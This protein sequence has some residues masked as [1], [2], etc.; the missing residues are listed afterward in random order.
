M[1]KSDHATTVDSDAPAD[2]IGM[3]DEQLLARLEYLEFGKEDAALL[4][5][6]HEQLRACWEK[7]GERFYAYL[8]STPALQPYLDD[9]ALARLKCHQSAYFSWL[10]QGRYD[11]EYVRNRI[12]VGLAHQRIGLAPEW[13]LGAYRKYLGELVPILWTVSGGDFSTFE[14]AFNALSK[15]VFFDIGIALDTYFAAGRKAIDATKNHDEQLLYRSTHDELTGFPNVLML[16]A[17][18]QQVIARAGQDGHTVVMILLNIDDFSR[19]NDNLAFTGGDALL[20]GFSQ[21]LHAGMPEASMVARYLGDQFALVWE[22][23]DPA[24]DLDAICKHVT[25]LVAEPFDVEECVVQLACRL[26]GVTYPA[27]AC[28]AAGM[29]KYCEL[30]LAD[31]KETGGGSTSVFSAE[32]RERIRR[33][34]RLENELRTAV[35]GNALH[36][37]YQPLADLQTGQLVSLEAIVQWQHPREGLL[38]PSR[39][40]PVA[41]D[42]DLIHGINAW[43]LR[44]VCRDIRAWM[45]NGFPGLRVTVNLSPKYFRGFRLASELEQALGEAGVEASL[46][47]LSVTESAL[48]SNPETSESVMRRL[49]ALGVSFTLDDFGSGHAALALVK[50]LPFDRV[51]IDPSFI[52]GI[53]DNADNAV[54]FRIIIS[55]AHRQGLKVVAK[56]VENEEQCEFLRRQMCDEIQGS[57]FSGAV[58]AHEVEALLRE[59]RRLPDHLLRLNRPSRTL[60]LV[61]D[62]PNILAAL[63][64][65]LRRDGYQILTAESGQEGLDLLGRNAVDVIVSDQRMPGMTGVE[66][67]RTAKSLYPNTVRIVLSG[68]TEL[69]SVTDAVNE[70]AIYKFLTKPWDD[71]LLSGHIAE[72]FQH[73]E[74]ADENKRLDLQVRTASHELAI[75]NRNMEELLRQ[76]QQQVHHTELSLDIVR[77]ILQHVSLPILGLDENDMVAF[78]NGTAESLLAGSGSILGCDGRLLLPELFEGMPDEASENLCCRIRRGN[79][80]FN[81]TMRPMGEKSRSRGKLIILTESEGEP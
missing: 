16:K 81:V 59:G 3:T 37:H 31:A 65:L 44:Q 48:T 47:S 68:Y 33:R 7:F 14:R 80:G 10:S 9:Q 15:I 17:H 19:V 4:S 55:M 23:S 66:F 79:A 53:P 72:A 40:L 30:A 18:L 77:E 52:Q 32:R 57:F 51:K 78:A 21:R 54:M 76:K 45:D 1:T 46:L 41:E 69:Q 24:S 34:I 36:L 35:A 56:G 73:K 2:V 5:G 22:L 62:E 60:L 39:F 8:C 6:M 20:K 29:L 12:A 38:A 50:R 28:D 70:G 67:L 64:R 27:D 71:G 61:D 11:Q 42:S 75:A 74:M 43:M 26:G 13:Y 63:K 49:T 58:P 25:E